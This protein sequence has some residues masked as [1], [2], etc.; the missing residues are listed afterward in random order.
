MESVFPS[1]E[2]VNRCCLVRTSEVLEPRVG[3]VK[4]EKGWGK[5]GVTA[6]PNRVDTGAVLKNV[7]SGFLM[8]I[9][10]MADISGDDVALGKE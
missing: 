4:S 6:Q 2:G 7:E 9:T 5:V 3:G 10:E 1:D 8:G